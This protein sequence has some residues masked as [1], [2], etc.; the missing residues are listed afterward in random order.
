MNTSLNF[1][2][3]NDKQVER[4]GRLL[5]RNDTDSFEYPRQESLYQDVSLR[6]DIGP[7]V[8][9]GRVES[10]VVEERLHCYIDGCNNYG[11]AKCQLRKHTEWYGCR[12]RVCRSHLDVRDWKEDRSPNIFVEQAVC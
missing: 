6:D 8:I 2:V 5:S 10:T 3:Q 7:G 9:M 1:D 11:T 4:G 12:Q